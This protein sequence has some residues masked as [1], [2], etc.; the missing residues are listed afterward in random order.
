MK[1]SIFKNL[2]TETHSI[3]EESEIFNDDNLE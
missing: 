2:A 3:N 1:R